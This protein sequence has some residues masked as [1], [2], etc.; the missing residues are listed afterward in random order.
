MGVVLGDDA[1]VADE[2]VGNARCLDGLELLRGDGCRE[3]EQP[4]ETEIG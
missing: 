4:V 1:V 3:K 2:L